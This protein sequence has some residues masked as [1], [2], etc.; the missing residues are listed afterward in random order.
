M[1]TY[2]AF[3]T[4]S[5]YILDA[6]GVGAAFVLPGGFWVCWTAAHHKHAIP[7]RRADHC[8]LKLCT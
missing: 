6:I 1:W 2:V 8:S 3:G 5:S 7:R 4:I